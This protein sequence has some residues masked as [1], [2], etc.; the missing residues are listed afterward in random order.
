MSKQDDN[1]FKSI[2]AAVLS[3]L[4]KST[5]EKEFRKAYRAEMGKNINNDLEEVKF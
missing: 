2:I 1:E 4:G 5:T 3:S